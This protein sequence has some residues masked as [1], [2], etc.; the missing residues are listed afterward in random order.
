MTTKYLIPRP[1]CYKG[2]AAIHPIYPI[3]VERET[4]K[5]IWVKGR[6]GA[7]RKASLHGLLCNT[8]AEA[9]AA[10]VDLRKASVERAR[11]ELKRQRQRVNELQEK[12]TKAEL[13]IIANPADTPE[14][15]LVDP[16]ISR[17]PLY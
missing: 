7:Y 15:L 4:D 6:R 9:V 1:F 12:I 5:S 2:L 3:E 17:A 16:S 8:L 14:Q 10:S 13:D 11:G